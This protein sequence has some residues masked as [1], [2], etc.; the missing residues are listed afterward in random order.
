MNNASDLSQQIVRI[1][2]YAAMPVLMKYGFDEG[3]ATAIIT[4]L[5]GFI[6]AIAWWFFWER[7]RVSPPVVVAKAAEVVPIPVGDQMKAGV[8]PAD[9]TPPAQAALPK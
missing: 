2:L 5:G 1:L 7:K 4:G 6:G 3:S 8:A 9:V